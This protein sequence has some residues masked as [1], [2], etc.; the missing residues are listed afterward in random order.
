MGVMEKYSWS[1]VN[2]KGIKVVVK[3]IQERVQKKEAR[4]VTIS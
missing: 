4:P 2:V 3:G 1:N